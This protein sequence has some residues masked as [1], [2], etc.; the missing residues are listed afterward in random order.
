[1]SNVEVFFN[2][3][4]LLS[5]QYRIYYINTKLAQTLALALALVLALAFTFSMSW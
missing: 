2:K 4:F 5:M 1:M 3:Y